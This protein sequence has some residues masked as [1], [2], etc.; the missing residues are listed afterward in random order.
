MIK[1]PGKRRNGGRELV[2]LLGRGRLE[3][4]VLEVRRVLQLIS[5]LRNERCLP[6]GLC[7][8]AMSRLQSPQRPVCTR[9]WRRV[10]LSQH[11][12]LAS[13]LE[14]CWVR[15]Q[16]FHL[17]LG[18]T[19]QHPH[20][21]SLGSSVHL[22]L[23]FDFEKCH[24]LR[25]SSFWSGSLHAVRNDDAD[26]GNLLGLPLWFMFWS[27]LTSR[28]PMS[29]QAGNNMQ[30]PRGWSWPSLGGM[31]MGRLGAV[32]LA[33]RVVQFVTRAF[34]PANDHDCPSARA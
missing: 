27:V 23:R 3:M 34:L 30:T 7:S 5:L 1:V 21:R 11:R 19:R 4:Q 15:R 24:F 2:L 20:R 13:L 29:W 28:P 12:R 31:Q 14:T 25:G 22:L 16:G 18:G 17:G 10:D 32:W 33:G 26:D 8:Q 6:G 9:G